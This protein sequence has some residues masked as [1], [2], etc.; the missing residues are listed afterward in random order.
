MGAR[1]VIHESV[2]QEFVD[3]LVKKVEGIR[4]GDP[5]S[6]ETQMGPVIS[7]ASRARIGKMV[8][9]ARAQGAEV[10]TGG[11]IPHMPAP[12]DKGSYY[13]PTVIKVTQSMEIWRE[14]V[15]GPVVVCVPFSTE[16]EAI[17]LANDSPYG[18]AGNKLNFPADV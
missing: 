11:C 4:L 1:L 17:T 8:D 5:T 10:L 16:E 7:H 14:E 9:H 6:M 3:R 13:A 2:Y 15:F 18:L 12:F